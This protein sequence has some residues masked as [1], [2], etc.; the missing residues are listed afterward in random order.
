MPRDSSTGD[1]LAELLHHAADD[2]EDGAVRKW[3]WSLLREGEASS[4]GHSADAD[5]PQPAA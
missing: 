1:P 3:L 4:G 2:C 5:R